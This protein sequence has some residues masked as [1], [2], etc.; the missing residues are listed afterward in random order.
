M[1]DRVVLVGMMGAGK[2]TVFY[3]ITG[4]VRPDKGVIELDD[5]ASEDMRAM[6]RYYRR[7]ERIKQQIVDLRAAS[8]ARRQRKLAGVLA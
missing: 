2:T 8:W 6:A 4:L 3:M 1:A 5:I 7:V